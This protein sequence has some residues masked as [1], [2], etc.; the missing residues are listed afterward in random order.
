MPKPTISRSEAVRG[1]VAT[2]IGGGDATP[3][4]FAHPASVR[5]SA[6]P[7][8]PITF[9][10]SLDGQVFATMRDKD[11]L[12]VR[13]TKAGVYRLPVPVLHLRPV[14]LDQTV[15]IQTFAQGA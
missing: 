5:V 8:H 10:G 11:G 15:T 14:T 1:R 6:D 12:E 9:E 2:W 13:I 3:F 7:T 4:I